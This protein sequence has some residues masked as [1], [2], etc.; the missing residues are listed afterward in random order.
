MQDQ[1]TSVF[2]YGTLLTGYGNHGLVS[3]LVVDVKPGTV[4]GFRLYDLGA[5]PGARP[6]PDFGVRGEMLTL[7]DPKEALRRL[8][9]LEGVPTLYTR[10]RVTVAFDDGTTGEAW[11]YVL[12]R[13]HAGDGRWGRPKIGR[14]SCRERVLFEV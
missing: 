8:D 4:S 6:A 10:E 2:V 13:T 11:I 3:G 1:T 14:A 7:E 5:F 9:R 12:A